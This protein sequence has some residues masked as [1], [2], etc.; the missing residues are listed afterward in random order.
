[1]LMREKLTPERVELLR[2]WKHSGFNINSDR[3][4]DAGDREALENGR[5]QITGIQGF[6]GE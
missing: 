1:M 2:S 3:R 6:S 4:I 5:F